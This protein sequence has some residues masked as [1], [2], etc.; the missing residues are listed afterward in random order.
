MSKSRFLTNL[1]ILAARATPLFI[2]KWVNRN[3]MLDGIMHKTFARIASLGG[4]TF[5][6]QSG[7]LA[8]VRLEMSEH[9]LSSHITGAYERDT[10]FAIDRLVRPGAICY[11][12]GASIGY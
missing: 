11:D 1:S 3:R 2:K 5:P 7:P 6:I 10:Q 8:G 4:P 9:V 12:L